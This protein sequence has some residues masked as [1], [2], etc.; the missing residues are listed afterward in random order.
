M[1]SSGS[2]NNKLNIDGC[3]FRFSLKTFSYPCF[4]DLFVVT[5]RLQEGFAHI[6]ILMSVKDRSW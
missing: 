5:M 1:S 6:G 3:K 4:K 2:I